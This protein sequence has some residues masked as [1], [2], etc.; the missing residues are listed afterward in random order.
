MIKNKES[1]CKYRLNNTQNKKKDRI[2]LENKN[3]NNELMKIVE[4]NNSSDIVVEF[5]DS[6]K[7][8][9]HTKWEHFYK[10][11][12][13]KNPYHAGVFN[14][15]IVGNKID[16][17]KTKYEYQKWHDIL[18]RCYDPKYHENKPSYINCELCD[19]W[20]LYENFYKWIVSQENYQKLKEIND[21]T[22]DKDILYKG[23]KIYSPNTCCLVPKHVNILFIKSDRKRGEFPM[24]VSRYHKNSNLFQARC[25]NV[26]VGKTVLIGLY[27]TPEEAFCAY[28]EYK[29][30]LIKQVAQEEYDKG[31][32]TKKCYEAMMNYEV[33]IT[34]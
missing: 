33:E 26:Y 4:Y 21:C 1:W 18:R 34:D 31:N 29:E 24:G 30:K 6:Y 9:V 8:K 13:V 27:E 3:N 11:K 28:K 2:G 17:K 14:V 22:I 25:N 16:Y 10:D 5:Q 32:I 7:A 23:N 20:R 12:S 19:N 15:G